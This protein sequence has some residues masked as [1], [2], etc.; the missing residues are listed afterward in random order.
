MERLFAGRENC[1]ENMTL[2]PPKQTKAMHLIKCV[3][4]SLLLCRKPA[5]RIK[6]DRQ[7]VLTEPICC[8]RPKI[9]IIGKDAD[10]YMY[11]NPAIGAVFRSAV[12]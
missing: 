11:N 4:Q 12:S 10:I 3:L 8:F 7:A 9:K 1:Q 6:T 2:F 5:N